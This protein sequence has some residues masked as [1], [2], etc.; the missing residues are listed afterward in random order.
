MTTYQR[1]L[2]M[3]RI[4]KADIV[5][6]GV[7]R[8]DPDEQPWA[9]NAP[10]TVRRK[11]FNDPMRETGQTLAA[12]PRI[13][14]RTTSSIEVGYALSSEPGR[15]VY[16]NSQADSSKNRPKRALAG[17]SDAALDECTQMLADDLARTAVEGW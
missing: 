14:N 17:A 1:L 2:A 7:Q 3:A 16:E 15:R 13:L 9:A 5:R 11:G 10:S 12:L 6:R 4:V 8:R